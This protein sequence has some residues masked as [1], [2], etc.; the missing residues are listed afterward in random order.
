[1][2]VCW[3]GCC[4]CCRR[5]RR[6]AEGGVPASAAGAPLAADPG[7]CCSACSPARCAGL[8][9]ASS[10]TKS[11]SSSSVVSPAAGHGLS[12]PLEKG[13]CSR[14]GAQAGH[15]TASCPTSVAIP[16]V[17]L[18]LRGRRV[19]LPGG[20]RGLARGLGLLGALL[21]GLAWPRFALDAGSSLSACWRRRCDAANPVLS[22]RVWSLLSRAS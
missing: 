21:L 18:C 12:Q 3:S 7:C 11:S 2:P 4:C 19:I 6:P 10:G 8:A 14:C 16:A 22:C 1:M 9:C 20:W 17:D 13:R 5:T 15:H